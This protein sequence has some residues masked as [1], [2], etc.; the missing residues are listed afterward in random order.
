MVLL[1]ACLAG[2]GTGSSG[3]SFVLVIVDALRADHL[4]CYGYH[5]NTSP[6]IDSIAAA[7]TRWTAVQAQAPWTLP[8]VSSILTGLDVRTHGTGRR[9]DD[10]FGLDPSIPTVATI[11]GDRGYQCCGLTNVYLLGEELGFDRGYDYFHCEPMGQYR[12]DETVD[13]A[14]E[15]IDGHGDGRFLVVMH[16][17]DVHD[18]YDPPVP[19]DSLYAD[20]AR[21]MVD[22]SPPEAKER[23]LAAREHLMGLYDGEIRWVDAQ[24]GRL[25]AGL[26]EMDLS[27]R[28]VVVIC[29]D[30]GQEFLE[31]GGV[32]HGKTL[33]QEV[34][35]VPLVASGPGI[36][37]GEVREI[38]AAQVDILPTILGL[39]GLEDL[40]VHAAGTDLLAGRTDSSRALPSSNLNTTQV[41]RIASVL[42][43]GK[44]LIWVPAADSAFTFDL[45]ADPDERDPLP[46]DSALMDSVRSYWATPCPYRPVRANR[47]R[48]D[49]ILKDLGYI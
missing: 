13:E 8:A 15:W 46:A 33:Y 36:P 43:Q 39:A 45:E 30:H 2:C 49:G 16:I 11:L 32:Y 47:E 21:G 34:L 28:T 44:K 38:P 12:A 22:W 9:G 3:P 41:P 17:F 35:S 5:R 19:Y 25:A 27:A 4:G 26:V 7:G 10:V 29:A 40:P 42:S 24:I 18:P 6:V 37:S 14:L 31:H 20:G 23:P 1:V 48:I